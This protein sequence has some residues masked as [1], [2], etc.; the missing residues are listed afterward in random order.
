MLQPISDARLAY[1]DVARAGALDPPAGGIA[2]DIGCGGGYLS[3]LL[4]ARGWRVV[5]LDPALASLVAARARAGRQG[6][7]SGGPALAVVAAA[8]EQSPV[9]ADTA[10]LAC[11]CDVLEHVDDVDKVV[12]EVA[13]VL[14][15]G[16]TFLFETINRTLASRALAIGVL[17]RWRLTRL[18]D[19]ELH[20]WDR[21]VRPSELAGVLQRHGLRLGGISGLAPRAS[22]RTTMSSF[23]AAKTGAIAFDELGR[24]L[25]I[26][27]VRPTWGA[28]LGWAL[29]P[30]TAAEPG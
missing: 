21:F 8:G 22:W 17:Q 15:P 6:G 26:G 16:G 10:A 30:R 2:L 11:C 4:L 29:K 27:P 5:G 23:V 7:V 25:Q 14:V 3:E 19:F 12:A 20:E 13:R 9:A 1:L 24:R 28:Y 18:V